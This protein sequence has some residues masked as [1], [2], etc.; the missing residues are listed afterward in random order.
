MYKDID[1]SCVSKSDFLTLCNECVSDRERY[2]KTGDV[3]A[4][5]KYSTIIS[6]IYTL[7]LDYEF[8]QFCAK[9]KTMKEIME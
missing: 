7:G 2:K 1:M 8:R 5:V 4:F 6:S 3:I 9:N